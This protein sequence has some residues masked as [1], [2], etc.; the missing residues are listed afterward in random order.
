MPKIEEKA[1]VS[2]LN[3]APATARI[4]RWPE[5]QT[6]TGICRSHAHDLVK[7]GK[8]P[9]PIKLGPR[10]SGWVE[11]D[12]DAWIQDRIECS[13]SATEPSGS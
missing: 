4:L 9:A 13:R 10:A 8:F 3:P 7:K 1:P 12:I 5:V 6:R 11:A 2:K